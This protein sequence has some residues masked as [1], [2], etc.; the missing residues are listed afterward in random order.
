MRVL[1]KSHLPAVPEHERK[2]AGR[3][4][5]RTLVELID[6]A[7]SGKHLHW[8][9]AGHGFRDVHLHLDELVDEWHELA[10]TVAERAVAI[11]CSVDGRARA[12]ADHGEPGPVD[13]GPV[14]VP[15][16]IQILAQRLAEVDEL[17]RERAD[18]AGALDLASQDVLIEVMRTLEKQLWMI[19]SQQRADG[20]GACRRQGQRST[21]LDGS[22]AVTGNDAAVR[23]ESLAKQ[24]ELFRSRRRIESP[25]QGVALLHAEIVDGPDIEAP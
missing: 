24:L 18:R 1:A 11:G 21:L 3:L 6:L 22:P 5:Q 16:A 13:A 9:I 10:D 17:V 12:V 7:L 19:R 4:L 23:P 20:S 8:N 25:N 14:T 2:E 15:Q